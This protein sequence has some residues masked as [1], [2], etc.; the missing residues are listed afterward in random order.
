MIELAR[1]SKPKYSQQCENSIVQIYEKLGNYYLD[2]TPQN[3]KYR[4]NVATS[5]KNL[6]EYKKREEP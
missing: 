3:N 1:I 2:V 5:L 6:A 4:N